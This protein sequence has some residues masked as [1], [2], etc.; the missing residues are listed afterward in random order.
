MAGAVLC[1]LVCFAKIRGKGGDQ[2]RMR[3]N[4]GAFDGFGREPPTKRPLIFFKCRGGR[5]DLGEK[6]FKED[7][8]GG[9]LG[10]DQNLES[11][12]F[13]LYCSLLLIFSLCLVW[14]IP[15]YMSKLLQIVIFGGKN[16]LMKNRNIL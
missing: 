14:G 5:P 7:G 16:V 13:F 9:P 3:G 11:L 2:V 15:S 4:E 1:P 8:G 10:K 12:M 6:K